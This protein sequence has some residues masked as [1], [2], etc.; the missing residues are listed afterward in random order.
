MASPEYIQDD[1]PVGARVAGTIFVVVL[2]L[3]LVAA[4]TG[5]LKPW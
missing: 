2:M 4:Y 5:L 1:E 3:G